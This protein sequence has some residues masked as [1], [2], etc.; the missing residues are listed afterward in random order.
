MSAASQL[1][2]TTGAILTSRVLLYLTVTGNLLYVSFICGFLN[3]AV[4]S[5]DY[6][7]SNGGMISES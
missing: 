4:G 1:L 5:S 6:V 3:D 7:G 2:A